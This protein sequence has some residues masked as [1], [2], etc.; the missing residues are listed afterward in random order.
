MVALLHR[1]VVLRP[2]SKTKLGLLFQLNIGKVMSLG[3]SKVPFRVNSGVLVS[4]FVL[5][6]GKIPLVMFGALL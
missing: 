1:E 2:D 5:K 3:G 4:S 6:K